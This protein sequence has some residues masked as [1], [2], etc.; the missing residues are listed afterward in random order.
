MALCEM[1][2]LFA[3][4]AYFVTHNRSFLWMII[5]LICN[6][7]FIYPSRDKIISQLQLNSSEQSAL[8]LD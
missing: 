4:I 3:I 2:T 7:L 8:G 5:L 6:F 1:P